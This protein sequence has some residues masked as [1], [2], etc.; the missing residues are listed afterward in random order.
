[1]KK[2]NRLILVLTIVFSL[3]LT[4]NVSGQVVP[5][6]LDPLDK[7]QEVY[8]FLEAYP[9]LVSKFHDLI[10]VLKQLENFYVDEKTKEELMNLAIKGMV[11]GLDPYSDL[12]IDKEV[13]DALKS[14][15]VENKYVGVGVSIM[16]FGR[17]CVVVSVFKNS[18]AQKAGLEPGDVILR[19]NSQN[20]SG[21]N[22]LEVANL[23]GGEANT[24]VEIE[25]RSKRF[26]KPRTFRL[27]RVNIVYSSVDT[28]DLGDYGYVKINRFVEETPARVREVLKQF[29]SR[30]GLIVDLRDNPG[31]N[32]NAV[33]EIVGLFV[34]S[35]RITIFTKERDNQYGQYGETRTRIEQEKYPPK[36]VILVNNFSASA[37]EILAGALQYYRVAKVVGV[38]T[39]GKAVGQSVGSIDSDDAGNIRLLLSLTTFRYFLPDGRSISET[40]VV[41]DVEVEQPEGFRIYEYG[42]KKDRQLQEAIKFLKR[43]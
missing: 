29:Q 26:Q 38:R 36:I 43:K 10:F 1:M 37:S 11:S 16:K 34:G 2:I 18:P 13:D 12:L 41:P 14:L 17:D 9:E 19:V 39:F 31:G 23:I 40:G 21:L 15:G 28:T 22:S 24:A 4:G 32:L 6:P 33:N 8:K 5:T 3:N 20:V 27:I 30:K 7:K 35:D 42:T 25:V